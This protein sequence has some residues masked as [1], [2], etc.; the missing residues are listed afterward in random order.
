LDTLLP[1]VALEC[2]I[3]EADRREF[4]SEQEI[5]GTWKK[6]GL[7]LLSSGLATDGTG[8]PESTSQFIHH[9]QEQWRE[10]AKE[11]DIQPQ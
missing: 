4:A 1:S 9:E 10:L 2:A 3:E 6:F 11:L 8:T 5:A 7:C